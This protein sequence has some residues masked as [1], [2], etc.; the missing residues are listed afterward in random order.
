MI[1]F[2]VGTVL[3]TASHSLLTLSLH[4]SVPAVAYF[5]PA[6]FTIIYYCA[7]PQH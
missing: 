6:D 1:A 7:T 4:C 3:L 2:G 5:V